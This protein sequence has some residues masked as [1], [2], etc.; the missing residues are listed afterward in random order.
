LEKWVREIFEAV[1]NKNI[2]PIDFSSIPPFKTENLGIEQWI[3][4]VKDIRRM[5]LL[6]PLPPQYQHYQQKP[7]QYLS[8]LL[9]HE[10]KES[11]FALIKKKGIYAS[12]SNSHIKTIISYSRILILLRKCL[13]F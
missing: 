6:W 3:V 1:P 8:H 12:Y 4:P 10:G 7:T 13:V 2:K 9:G 11:I 5:R